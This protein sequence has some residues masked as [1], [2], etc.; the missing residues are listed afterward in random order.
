M[1]DKRKCK[2][3]GRTCN[4]TRKYGNTSSKE[5]TREKERE[6]KNQSLFTLVLDS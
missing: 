1:K 3:E 2:K 5:R 6:K 4:L